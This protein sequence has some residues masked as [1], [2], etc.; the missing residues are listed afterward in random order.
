MSMP[1]ILS[2]LKPQAPSLLLQDQAAITDATAL[3]KG[4][5]RQKIA[6]M[7]A[8]KPMSGRRREMIDYL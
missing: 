7:C 8:L 4:G 6:L 2:A 5:E 1:G 3:I